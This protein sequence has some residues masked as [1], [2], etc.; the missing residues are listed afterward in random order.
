MINKDVKKVLVIGSGPIVIGQA[1]EFDYAGT[2]ACR[3]LREEGVE[4]VLVNSNPST[5]MTDVDI[6]DRVYI[7]P[8]TLPFVTEVIKKERP[9]A[10][11]ATLGGQVG[12]NM[13]VQLADAGVLDKYNV[14]LLG[15]S[16][17]AIKH[18][19]DRE[20]FKEA[21]EEIHQPVPESEIFEDLEPAVAFADKIGYP[22]IIAL[23]IHWAVQAAALRM[24]A[25]K[26][27]K[28]PTAASSF[29][30]SI[31]FWLNAA[32]PAGKK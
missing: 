1:A 12:L 2:Q 18:A 5:I 3:S 29:L 27:K 25:M 23:L 22:V 24:T 6:A 16:L 20:L 7:E 30:R 11:L 10:L 15:S 32:S 13:A 26:W 14:K 28:S 31:R 21:M 8:I 4:V 17:H 19:E 9:D